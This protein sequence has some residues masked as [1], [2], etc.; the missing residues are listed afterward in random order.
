MTLVLT[1]KDRKER[2]ENA[3]QVSTYYTIL[4]VAYY[5]S[6][7]RQKEVKIKSFLEKEV[8]DLSVYFD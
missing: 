1:F 6:L 4:S 5:T 8:L 3:F 7:G 2:I